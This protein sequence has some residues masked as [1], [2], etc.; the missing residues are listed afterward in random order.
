[1]SILRKSSLVKAFQWHPYCNKYAVAFKTD[2]VKIYASSS[3]P[4]VVLRHQKQVNVT[5]IAWK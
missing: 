3:T 4:Q 2:L 1:M 5:C